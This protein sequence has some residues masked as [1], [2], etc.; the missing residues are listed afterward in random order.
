MTKENKDKI[1]DLE[2]HKCALKMMLNSTYGLDEKKTISDMNE[3][4]NGLSSIN[5]KIRELKK[6]SK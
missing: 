2:F 6:S 4:M 3:I 5:Q 1:K